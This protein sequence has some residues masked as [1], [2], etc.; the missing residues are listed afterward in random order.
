MRQSLFLLIVLSYTATSYASSVITSDSWKGRFGDQLYLYAKTKW[1]TNK[2]NIQ[3]F[4][5]LLIFLIGIKDD[6][7]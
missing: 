3:F 2:F 7:K 4:I 5:N 6:D 1:I